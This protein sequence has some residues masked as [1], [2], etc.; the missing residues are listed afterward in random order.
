MTKKGKRVYTHVS[1][2]RIVRKR[3][4]TWKKQRLHNPY[5]WIYTRIPVFQRFSS[6][7]QFKSFQ[8]ISRFFGYR[9]QISPVDR[10]RSHACWTTRAQTRARTCP[11][12]RVNREKLRWHTRP[13][14]RSRARRWRLFFHRV[15]AT[16]KIAAP[17]K[18]CAR[19][20]AC[21]NNAHEHTPILRSLRVHN[22]EISFP[23]V[24]HPPGHNGFSTSAFLRFQY[25]RRRIV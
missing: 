14:K 19:A 16:T 23:F 15:N 11:E 12:Q 17:T 8:V 2:R 21:R 4:A 9:N 3:V 20:R 1:M 5:P 22:A 6:L 7:R 25:Q 10:V 13:W 24:Y 18:P